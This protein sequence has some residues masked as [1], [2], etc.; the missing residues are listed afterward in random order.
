VF[1]FDHHRVACLADNKLVAIALDPPYSVAEEPRWSTDSE[2]TSLIAHP[3]ANL[4]FAL[5]SA[6]PMLFDPQHGFVDCKFS[7]S[8]RENKI[9]CAAFSP[10]GSK[11]AICSDVIDIFT[12]DLSKW[13]PEPTVKRQINQI[14]TA[15]AWLNSDNLLAVAYRQDSQ[16]YLV[17]VD[18]LAKYNIPVDVKK[19][20]GIVNRIAVEARTKGLVFGTNKRVVVVC[21]M[22]RN[23]DHIGVY[24]LGNAVTAMASLYELFVVGIDTGAI[25]AFS[26]AES[27]VPERLPTDAKVTSLVVVENLMVA[28]GDGNRV[29]IWRVSDY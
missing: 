14:I 20:W 26:T 2:V 29:T 18:T 24:T 13:T 27:G 1:P 15:V 3:Q 28:A 9:T 12:F 4:F 16:A 10:N 6:G 23:F 25:V 5:S 8:S 21:D 11:L 19:E 22:R 17:V 7:V